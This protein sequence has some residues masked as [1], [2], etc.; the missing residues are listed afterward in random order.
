MNKTRICEVRAVFE[1]LYYWGSGWKSNESAK[2]WD[3]YLANYKGNYWRAI[4]PKNNMS[5]WHL[6]SS[7]GSI[8][9]H[10]MDFRTVLHSCGGVCSGKTEFEQHFPE[11]EELKELCQG[12][13]EA[14]GGK[15]S[16]MIAET[17]VIENNH[18]ESLLK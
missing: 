12:L 17:Q 13:A 11:L 10:P 18:F 2:A 7:S 3:E 4:A 5:C 1:G 14:C 15:L 16:S 6:M 9:L 8:Y